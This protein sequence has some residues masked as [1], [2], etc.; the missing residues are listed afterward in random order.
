MFVARDDRESAIR[1]I[2]TRR[3][4]IMACGAEISL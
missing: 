1:R 4:L 2:T 3:D